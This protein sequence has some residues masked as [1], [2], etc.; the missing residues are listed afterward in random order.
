VR[1]RDVFLPSLRTRERIPV[2]ED[3][4]LPPGAS[5]EGP[6]IVDATDTTIFVPPGVTA[7]RDEFLNYLLTR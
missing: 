7:T 3:A 5:V 2:Y 1:E 6:A 4:G